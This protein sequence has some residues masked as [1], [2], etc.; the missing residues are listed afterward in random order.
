MNGPCTRFVLNHSHAQND[1]SFG[2]FIHIYASCIERKTAEITWKFF[3]SI[4]NAMVH[5]V[6]QKIKFHYSWTCRHASIEVRWQGTKVLLQLG[7]IFTETSFSIKSFK[8][9]EISSFLNIS[10]S[11]YKYIVEVTHTIVVFLI[12]NYFK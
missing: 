11:C 9:L 6:V 12:S 4:T 7:V 1:N 2:I 3:K 5:I 8:H 10:H